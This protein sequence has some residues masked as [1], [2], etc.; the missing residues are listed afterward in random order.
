MT[1]FFA[2]APV[3]LAMSDTTTDAVGT[4]KYGFWCPCIASLP[5]VNM[6]VIEGCGSITSG[7]GVSRAPSPETD[8]T[9]VAFQFA[10]HGDQIAFRGLPRVGPCGLTR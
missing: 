5:G 6:A 4:P 3:S 9:C 10:A 7:N 8:D 1:H 2:A